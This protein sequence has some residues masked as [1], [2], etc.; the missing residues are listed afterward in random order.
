[1]G[2]DYLRDPAAIYAESFRQV[3]AS[4]D[5]SGLP[6]V[7]HDVALRLVHAIGD[8]ALVPDLRWSKGAAE[9]ARAALRSGA[10]VYADCEMAAAGV[11]RARLPAANKVRCT[12]NRPE[13]P[14]LAKQLGTTRS[15][16]AVEAWETKGAVIAIGN[17][18]TALFHLLE[19][20][21]GGAPVPACIL[22]FC[23][24]FVGAA[25][26]KQALID[27]PYP[28]IA[29]QG[30]RG[31]SALAAAAVNALASDAEASGAAP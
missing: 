11:T 14:L 19:K 8:P 4:T 3:R 7:L 9:A 28:F 23:V 20:L 25:E 30:R 31:G 22:G 26:A 2:Y 16:A 24:G 12:L 1:V 15:A 21:D 6:P 17:A 13:V 29:L 27:S 18:P 5:L 10:P